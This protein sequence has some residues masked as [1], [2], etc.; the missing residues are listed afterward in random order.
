MDYGAT[1]LATVAYGGSATALVVIA[2][3]LE[4]ELTQIGPVREGQALT[5]EAP[6][7][8]KL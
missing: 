7:G 8:T 2:P 3:V 5:S 6:V 4:L 1:P